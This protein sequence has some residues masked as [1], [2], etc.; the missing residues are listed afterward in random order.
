MFLLFN[1]HD[2]GINI[3]FKF[4]LCSRLELEEMHSWLLFQTLLHAIQLL[5]TLRSKYL[6]SSLN[7]TWLLWIGLLVGVMRVE[8]NGI[9]N[10]TR[11]SITST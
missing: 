4:I 3:S 7:Q 9:L 11:V 6:E 10:P 5:D 1:F 8:K 2:K